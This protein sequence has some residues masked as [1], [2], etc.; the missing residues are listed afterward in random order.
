VSLRHRLA[1]DDTRAR[2]QAGERR[3]DQ[4][5][6][7]GQVIAGPAVESHPLTILAGDDSESIVLALLVASTSVFKK[8]GSVSG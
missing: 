1:V 3:D 8:L 5:E 6:A 7:V 4:R 2:A